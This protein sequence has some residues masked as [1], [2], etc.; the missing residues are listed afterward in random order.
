MPA[1]ARREQLMDAALDII[2]RD[3]YRA[4]SVEAVVREVDVT[5][6]VFYNVYDSLDRLLSDLLDRQEQRALARLASTIALPTPGT[7]HAEYL[8]RTV[9]D[10]VEMVRADPRT[11]LPIFGA[12][13]DTPDVVRARIA[14]DREAVRL[15]FRDF[16]ALAVAD[17]ERL[18]AD[19]LAHSLVAVGEYFARRILED[20][21]SVD[22][23]GL[24]STLAALVTRA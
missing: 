21:Q 23:D 14:R 18:D 20:P 6:P 4:V 15:R 12:A 16:V 13:S 11:W 17:D 5:R 2:V 3:G 7:D 9:R 8:R 10:L 1:A 22:A 19:L 24:A